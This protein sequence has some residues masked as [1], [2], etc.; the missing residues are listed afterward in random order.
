MTRV[1]T[2]NRMHN[3]KEKIH[4]LSWCVELFQI[5]TSRLDSPKMRSPWNPCRHVYV[6]SVINDEIQ[7]LKAACNFET[8]NHLTFPILDMTLM[9]A[10][11]C[12]DGGHLQRERHPLGHPRPPGRPLQPRPHQLWQVRSKITLCCRSWVHINHIFKLCVLFCMLIL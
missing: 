8:L 6:A 12:F 1:P 2:V 11:V 10:G 9:I 5:N 4:N 3:S 7:L